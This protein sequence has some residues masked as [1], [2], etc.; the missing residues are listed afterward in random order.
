VGAGGGFPALAYVL[1][2]ARG[3]GGLVALYRRLASRNACKTCALGMGGARGGMTNEAGHFPEVCK[4]SV[5]AQAADMGGVVDEA[6]LARTPLAALERMSARELEAAG[7]VAF[8]LHAGPGATHLRRI[9]WDELL[10]RAGEAFGAARP[11]ETFFYSSGR[12][13]NEAGFL[14]QLVARAY[15]TNNVNNCSY[16]CHQASGVALRDIY[17]SGTASV[18]LDDRPDE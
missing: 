6:F 5:Q 2:K 14:M 10:A 7:R 11:D 15:G 9:S 4:K 3:A 13:S 17:G 18:S 1:R 16:Y 12:S 8:P